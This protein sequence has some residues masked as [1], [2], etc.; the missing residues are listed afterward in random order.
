V[1]VF[2]TANN[3]D[4][5]M[6]SSSKA[7]STESDASTRA[8]WGSVADRA[9]QRPDSSAEQRSAP[10]EATRFAFKLFEATVQVV[11]IGPELLAARVVRLSGNES[12]KVIELLGRV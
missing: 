12:E 1:A 6:D 9:V 4:C 7:A 10:S 11:K 3:R 8:A 5:T 2:S